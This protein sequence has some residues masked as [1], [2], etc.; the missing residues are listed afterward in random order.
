MYFFCVQSGKFTPDRNFYTGSARGARDKYEVWVGVFSYYIIFLI[1][2]I[3]NYYIILL[4]ITFCLI[5][6]ICFAFGEL[7][8]PASAVSKVKIL[9]RC[10][11]S[12]PFAR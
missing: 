4:I 5:R 1:I 6:L 10:P 11:F 2:T 12:Q 3:I 9:A 7:V 8:K